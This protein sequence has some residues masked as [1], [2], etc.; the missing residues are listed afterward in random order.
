MGLF[1]ALRGRTPQVAPN[2]DALFGISTGALTLESQLDLVSSGQAGLC[3][4]AGSGAS[5]KDND[6]SITEIL[7]IDA[8]SGHVSL[9]TDDLGFTWVVITDT[10]VSSLAT[11]LHGANATLSDHGYGPR[12]LCAAFGFLPKVAPGD[13]EVHMIY[14]FKR[15]TWYPFAG[16]SNQRRNNELELRVRS[17]VGDDLPME[18]D[19]SRWMALWNLPVA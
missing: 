19:L 18:K 5:E 15:G 16:Q 6:Q 13:G 10:D 3:F 9:T 2:L 4:K 12:L 17:F 14:L 11:R 1:D 7:S 8:A